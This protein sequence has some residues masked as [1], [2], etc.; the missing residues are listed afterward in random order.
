VASPS[1]RPT[2]IGAF[3]SVT[4]SSALALLDP[5]GLT[6][7]TF[8]FN[9]AV[10]A[11]FEYQL[12]DAALVP[13]E[14][15]AVAGIDGVRWLRAVAIEGTWLNGY[16]QYVS[17]EGNDASDGLGWNTAKKTGWAAY[18]TLVP[19]NG[20]QM[21]LANNVEWVDNT[22]LQ[23]GQV[24][25]QGAWFRADGGE[26]VFP[27]WQKSCGV[28]ITGVGPSTSL[29]DPTPFQQPGASVLF[30][31]SNLAADFRTKPAVW[32]AYC[33][34]SP[35][36]RNIQLAPTPG[37]TDG[38]EGLYQSVR[39]G[40]DY[41]RNADGSLMFQ[42]VTS[43]QRTGSAGAGSTV[44][45]CALSPAAHISS[46]S[47]DS[48]D[49]T[50]LGVTAAGSGLGVAAPP[51]APGTKI[52]FAST[53]GS[54]T[55]GD[56]TVLS[57]NATQ[58][59]LS[60]WSVTIAG[61]GTG[62]QAP[63]SNPG[64][65]RS[66]IAVVGDLVD[67]Q[68]TD[69]SNYPSTQY[70]VT[71]TSI[72]SPTAGT[73]TVLDRWGGTGGIPTTAGPTSNIGNLVHQDRNYFVTVSSIYRNV[74]TRAP[75]GDGTTG[76]YLK[77]GPAWDFGA[78]TAF[79]QEVH[80]SYIE[81]YKPSVASGLPYDDIQHAGVLLMG[82]T[83]TAPAVS[84]DNLRATQ[85]GLRAIFNNPGFAASTGALVWN[86]AVLD[87]PNGEAPGPFIIDGNSS[88]TVTIN[89]VVPADFNPGF[90]PA[91]SRITGI[92]PL[93]IRGNS[94]AGTWPSLAPS[95]NSAG[96]GGT[97][98]W[99]APSVGVW[100][101]DLQLSGRHPAAWRSAGAPSR[102][103]A[104]YAQPQTSY[105]VNPT[106]TGIADPFGGTGAI[107]Y[108]DA[109]GGETLIY[110]FAS[111]F[112]FA[113]GDSVVVCG[114][115]NANATGFSN[116][117]QLVGV[118]SFASGGAITWDNGLSHWGEA[119]PFKGQGWQF[120]AYRHKIATSTGT[121]NLQTKIITPDASSGGT[122]DLFGFSMLWIPHTIS[123]NDIAQYVGT[124]HAMPNYLPVGEAG[125]FEGQ[126]LIGHGGLGTAAR[127]VVGV[128]SGEITLTG[129]NTKAVELF[130][131]A[132]NSLGVA[133]LQGFTVN[134]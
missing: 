61:E 11:Y 63:V 110:S 115:V 79:G 18:A 92:P 67:L 108:D 41:N 5:S 3:L 62:V 23:P 34:I 46:A 74:N 93:L 56:Y 24:A 45:A 121:V 64:T 126:K 113:V 17:P 16:V 89:D 87:S 119:T 123:D 49:I 83:V 66:I 60:D 19:F 86:G 125:T 14:V 31:G 109:A 35:E 2:V 85:F 69:P 21:F 130:D 78:E 58:L 7:G 75:A 13:D 22:D 32:K 51:W 43:A 98:P 102:R 84:I 82:G 38:Q 100:G 99:I 15:V 76:Q 12:S 70:R 124:L 71:D 40:W 120:V 9:Q 26:N 68:S 117:D 20:G 133:V 97:S 88:S 91:L 122:L 129:V 103:F 4:D 47:R 36:F 50:T 132:G 53:S 80:D 33:A 30:G 42:A 95:S 27:G 107:Q 73:I 116:I 52:H 28:I 29:G 77:F 90:G 59:G 105:S 65:I 55:T 54:F 104:E 111:A 94:A 118:S 44:F 81:G 6:L 57:V 131:E 8:V 1:I 37:K 96:G 39:D 128:A 25:G 112:N 10:N 101:G 106:A 134:P 114:W 72:T 48:S 127:Y